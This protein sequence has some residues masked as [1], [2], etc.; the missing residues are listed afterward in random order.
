MIGWSLLQV[1]DFLC[2]GSGEGRVASGEGT[3]KR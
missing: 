1:D 2:G 3:E